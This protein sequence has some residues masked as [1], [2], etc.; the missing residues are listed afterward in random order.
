MTNAMSDT[1]RG[2]ARASWEK[3][4]YYVLGIAAAV[5]AYAVDRWQPGPAGVNASTIH[6]IAIG[7]LFIAIVTGMRRVRHTICHKVATSAHLL[8][9]EQSQALP[10]EQSD[11]RSAFSDSSP[12]T[13]SN[14]WREAYRH[15]QLQAVTEAATESHAAER[16]GTIRDWT[17]IAGAL[18]IAAAKV[19]PVTPA[20]C[21]G[22]SAGQ[23]AVSSYQETQP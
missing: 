22:K 3:Y 13:Q 10:V 17:L 1:V 14:L 16:H 12:P 8:T 4:D 20:C 23:P 15:A 18:L 7:C 5:F 11:I 19:A 6:A 9:Q 21:A 2:E